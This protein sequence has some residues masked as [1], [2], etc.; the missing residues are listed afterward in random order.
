MP[1]ILVDVDDTL[2]I[3]DR[4]G[5]HPCGVTYGEPFKSNIELIERIKRFK[6]E[7]I[8]WSGGG[9]GYAQKVAE[10]VL[11]KD[12]PFKAESKGSSSIRNMGEGDVIV[13]DQKEYFEVLKNLG[14]KVV[15]PFENWE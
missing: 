14:V 4:Q 10:I 2:V 11:P 15:S 13:D 3:Y 7:I 12:L 5:L 8:I 6:G 9:A 1:R